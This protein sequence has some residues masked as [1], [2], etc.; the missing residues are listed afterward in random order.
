MNSSKTNPLYVFRFVAAIA[1]VLYHQQLDY[2][3]LNNFFTYS[4]DFVNFFF[5]LS[6]FVMVVAYKKFL[7]KNEEIPKWMFWKKRIQRIFPSYFIA[8]MLV[9]LFHYFIKNTFTSVTIKFPFEFAMVQSWIYGNSL[10][11]PAWSVSCEIFFYLLFPYYIHRV[12]KQKIKYL[13]ILSFSTLAIS[14]FILH[15]CNTLQQPSHHILVFSGLI[16]NHP[17]FRMAVFLLGNI[18]GIVYCFYPNIGARF[19]KNTHT[20][21]LCSSIIIILVFYLLPKNSTLLAGGLL[22]PI[23][24]IFILSLCNVGEKFNTALSNRYFLILG[25]ISYSVYILQY[26]VFLFFEYLFL[27]IVSLKILLLYLLVLI[28]ISWVTFILVERPLRNRLA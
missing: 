26:P 2:G 10:N 28:F 25:E 27:P 22:A 7:V 14:I 15:Y 4:C 16:N 17:V 19:S 21:L 12:F 6:G 20:F 18:G 3:F 9:L 11:Y 8:F 23:Y 1:V 24:I 13:I 5:V